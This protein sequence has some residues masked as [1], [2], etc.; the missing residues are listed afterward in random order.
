MKKVALTTILFKFSSY[1]NTNCG[2]YT[3]T[4][5]QSKCNRVFEKA[6]LDYST[7]LPL[8]ICEQLFTVYTSSFPYPL[9]LQGAI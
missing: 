3:G 9:K 6:I 8:N 1:L 2:L 4:H 7:V 5:T